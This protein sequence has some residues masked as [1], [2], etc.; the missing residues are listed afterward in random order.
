MKARIIQQVKVPCQEALPGEAL[1]TAVIP[2]LN[3]SAGITATLEA[4]QPA[5]RCGWLEVLVAD[6]GSRDGTADL[7]MNRADRIIRSE[8]GRAR[9]M[10]AGARVARGRVLWFLHADTLPPT[11]AVSLILGALA[12]GRRWG[13]FDVR[14]SG[15]QPMLRV[16]ERL[17][18]LR[19][20]ISGIATGD[21]AIFVDAVLFHAVG[22]FP[23]ISLM[24]D[25]AIS[26]RLR[27]EAG[28]PA[29]LA[30]TVLS[31]SRRWERDGVM[32]TILLMWRLRLAYWLGSDPDRLR[33]IY[34]GS[35]NRERDAVPLS[36]R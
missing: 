12:R 24:E 26:A 36:R 19:S 18:N 33:D 21:Q 27:G 31:S 3:E 14:L 25:V 17:M 6:G 22:G 15:G 23:D 8:A 11:N 35:R 13:R 7:A 9:Q 10:N 5:R 28:W 2:A 32:K 29:C 20:R 30:Q 1:V 4:L 34:Y 16:V